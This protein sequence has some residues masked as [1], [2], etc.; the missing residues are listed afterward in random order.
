[1]NSSKKIKKLKQ[2]FKQT[3]TFLA[4]PQRNEGHGYMKLYHILHISEA[5]TLKDAEL[6]GLIFTFMENNGEK[7]R[8]L[9][10]D[11]RINE[12][13]EKIEKNTRRVIF[14]D[15]D[16]KSGSGTDI[17]KYLD[18]I[19]TILIISDIPTIAAEARIEEAA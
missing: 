6:A 7:F 10:N 4:Q 14:Q 1:M 2:F 5:L 3:K 8:L 18:F 9:D 13:I 17:D 19:N 11:I 15:S 16:V 12:M